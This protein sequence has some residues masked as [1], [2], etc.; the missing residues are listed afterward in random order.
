MKTL[1]LAIII[2]ICLILVTQT[3]A[4][5]GFFN[6]EQPDGT[7]ITVKEMG[8]CCMFSWY[9]T[10]EGYMVQKGK[11]K[12]Y[13]YITMDTKGEFVQLPQW[14]GKDKNDSIPVRPYENPTI[15]SA[16][17]EKVKA[18]NMAADKNRARFLEKQRKA[19][20][21]DSDGNI[22]LGK[23]ALASPLTIEIGVI[24]VEFT[25]Q[26]HYTGGGGGYKVDDFENMLFSDDYYHT[27]DNSV[28]SPDDE[29]VFGSLRDYFEYQSH[30]ILT[31]TGSI[32]NDE[33]QD[34][35]P[36][37]IDLGN[38][39]ASYPTY[40]GN[41]IHADIYIDA[42]NAAIDSSWNV[43]QDM[44]IVIL[45]G[46][47]SDAGYHQWGGTGYPRSHI[48]KSSF[49]SSFHNHYDNNWFGVAG[50]FERKSST[51]SHIGIFC[52]EAF[53]VMGWGIPEIESSG[54]QVWVHPDSSAQDWSSMRTGYRTGPSYKGSCPG[55]L[56]AVARIMMEWA[57][58]IDVSTHL[59]DESVSYIEEDDDTNE[60]MDFYRLENPYSSGELIVE[61]RQYSGFNSYLPEWWKQVT[62][63]GLLVWWHP[64][65]TTMLR[66]LRPGDN[67]F[68]IMTVP[69]ESNWSAGDAGDPFPGTSNN[70]AITPYTTP[71]TNSGSNFTGLAVTNIST[72]STAMTA[73]FYVNYW[74][75]NITNNTTW[76]SA[77]SPYYVGG[78]IT[79]ASGVT[80]TIQSGVTVNFLDDDDQSG[81]LDTDRVELIVEGTLLADGVTFTSPSTSANDWYGIVLDGASS[82]TTIEN[83]SIQWALRGIIIDDCSPTIEGNELDNNQYG[84]WVH[85]ST[86]Q[87]TIT[88]NDIDNGS[89][90]LVVSSSAQPYIIDNKSKGLEKCLYVASGGYPQFRNNTLY[91][92]TNGN[93][94][95]FITGSS[96]GIFTASSSGDGNYFTDDV[97]NDI[98]QIDG[99]SYFYF[100]FDVFEDVGST[101]YEYIDNNDATWCYAQYCYWDNGGVPNSA[102]FDGNVNYDYELAT[103]P[104]AGV[105][106]KRV[107]QDPSPFASGFDAFDNNDYENAAIY[108]KEAFENNKDHNDSHKALYYMCRA[109]MRIADNSTYLS[110]LNELTESSYDEESKQI[111]RSFLIK[112]ACNN[113][114]L[115][116]AESYA[117]QAPKGQLYDRELLLDMVYYYALYEDKEGEQRI[118]STLKKT[119]ADDESLDE[120]IENAK[121]LVDDERKLLA[122]KQVKEKQPRSTI[123]EKPENVALQAF[124]NPFNP[125][126]N[127]Q[128]ALPESQNV[129]I[130]I[131]DVLGRR[132][133]LL[134]DRKMDQGVQQVVWDGRNGAGVDVAAGIYFAKLKTGNKV[135]T[136]KLL[137]VR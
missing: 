131:Y 126:T 95:V 35:T 14:A 15:A 98:V 102:Y 127:I 111:A 84:I 134:V 50:Y 63:G 103:E 117:F 34:G 85:G 10:P 7:T 13:H 130:Q 122:N 30:G 70:T 94:Q 64:S 58:A 137:L 68:D 33:N 123:D 125:S 5:K 48:A 31:V 46:S 51:F 71:S 128:F 78:D 22:S 28:E 116:Q 1:K 91:G 79:V 73:N 112:D 107:A 86:S 113:E 100:Y 60:T 32:V 110:F 54:S 75:G 136:I 132:V 104:S 119:Y 72:S 67:D 69:P 4:Q 27:E 82:T 83:S 61:N 80:L 96:S 37:W 124:P 93:Y 76:S 109:A 2:L 20:G 55:D 115:A 77:N 57:D 26:T 8:G 135:Q 62:H 41:A 9:E 89:L 81:G 97:T 43:E 47:A 56:D 90:P 44:H 45:A 129:H 24:L 65:A 106:W 108:L 59:V 87:P 66:Y 49:N 42:I 38:T 19:L 53:H 121:L 18:Y 52:H 114:K 101:S 16:F 118:V 74:S 6:L 39:I 120:A 105:T 25:D 23:A 3:K 40:S 133:K 36:V 12:F 88:E 29:N 99:G 17:L 92:Y 21:I 11:D